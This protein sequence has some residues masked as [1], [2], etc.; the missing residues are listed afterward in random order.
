M[1]SRVKELA[2]KAA[3]L[4]STE[5]ISLVDEILATVTE[6]DP[7][8][9]TAWRLEARERMAGYERGEIAA[10]DADEVLTAL[11]VIYPQR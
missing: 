11:K 3:L 7:D 4:S 9:T 1:S 2:E 6:V 10:E 8:W 5:K